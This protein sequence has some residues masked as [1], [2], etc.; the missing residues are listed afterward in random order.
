MHEPATVKLG[1]S[2]VALAIGDLNPMG[3]DT[4]DRGASGVQGRLNNLG[5]RAGREDGILGPRTVRSIILFQKL[6]GLVE[7]GTIT[8]DLRVR[9]L[10]R[11]GV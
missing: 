8:G 3:D 4:P 11:H 2:V 7:N 1:K 10:Q 9:L 5:L 6:E